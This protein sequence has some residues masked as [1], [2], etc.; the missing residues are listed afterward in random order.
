MRSLGNGRAVMSGRSFVRLY[1]AREL[2]AMDTSCH[3]WSRALHSRPHARAP[4]T[5]STAVG[6]AVV[7]LLLAGCGGS[8]TAPS[9]TP[10]PTPNPAPPPAFSGTV[11]DTVT[12]APVSGF[13]AV[14]SGSRLT[15]SAPGYLTRE[16]SNRATV[17][18]IPA[19]IDLGFYRQLARNGFETTVLEP[20]RVLTQAPSL[21]LQTVGLSPATVAALEQ[22]ARVAVFEFSGRR[23]GVVS[24]E[25]GPELRPDRS[26]WITVAIVNTPAPDPCGRALIGAPAGHITLNLSARC[27]FDRYG[28]T[29]F[30]HEVGHAL[31]FWHVANP[32]ALMFARA[33]SVTAPTA[34]ERSTAAIAYARLP[35]NRDIDVD[36]GLSSLA[37][38][39]ID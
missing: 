38:M 6:I 29:A 11:T 32:D 30:A 7:A 18:L 9:P 15:I 34:I 28:I 27:E 12:G 25:S 19:S 24:V 37:P 5:P 22:A 13:T 14:L 26:G 21:Y 2:S 8:P 31:G 1:S 36:G 4:R 3:L 39:V 10:Q 20:L 23:F 16:T 17:D 35:G 33:A